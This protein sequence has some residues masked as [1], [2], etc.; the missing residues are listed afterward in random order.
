MNS[1]FSV[2][3]DKHKQS[4]VYFSVRLHFALGIKRFERMFKTKSG[5]EVL[6]CMW[7]QLF[8]EEIIMPLGS[9]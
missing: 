9:K 6:S 5:K 1:S 7:E 4:N 8:A 3:I 2:D